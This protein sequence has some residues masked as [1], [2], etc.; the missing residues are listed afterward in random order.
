MVSEK[1]VLEAQDLLCLA[2][3]NPDA[4]VRELLE[5]LECAREAAKNGSSRPVLVDAQDWLDDP[6]FR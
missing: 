6:M 1:M 4:S 3:D 2:R 5:A